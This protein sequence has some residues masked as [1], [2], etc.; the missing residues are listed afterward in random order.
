M[1]G[2]RTARKSRVREG[3]MDV[4]KIH[5]MHVRNGQRMGTGNL[6]KLRRNFKEVK[7]MWRR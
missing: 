2:E 4:F 6:I 7:E 1:G 3:E 5:C